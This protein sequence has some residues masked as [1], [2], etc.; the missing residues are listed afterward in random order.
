MAHTR[1]TASPIPVFV[2]A[3]QNRAAATGDGIV[4]GSQ[5]DRSSKRSLVKHASTSFMRTANAHCKCARADSSRAAAGAAAAGRQPEL[6]ARP[7]SL[8]AL[9]QEFLGC[10][11]TR[12]KTK[13]PLNTPTSLYNHPMDHFETE[14]TKVLGIKYP[15]MCAGMVRCVPHAAGSAACVRFLSSR[16]QTQA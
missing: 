9:L 3:S 11:A 12:Q 13:G 4:R 16:K 2:S 15:I 6:L 1:L 5:L 10:L 8:A 14:L 7:C